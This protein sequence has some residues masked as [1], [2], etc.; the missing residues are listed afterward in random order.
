VAARAARS[1]LLGGLDGKTIAAAVPGLP[2]DFRSSYESALLALQAQP[3]TMQLGALS[4]Y[5]EFTAELRPFL[6]AFSQ[7]GR[8]VTVR[9]ACRCC[10]HALL[11]R[12]AATRVASARAPRVAG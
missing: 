9:G 3:A 4:A 11:P 7:S 8:V 12:V 10:A 2:S 6:R 5:D 1:L